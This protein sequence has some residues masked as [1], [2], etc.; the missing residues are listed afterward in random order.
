MWK[1]LRQLAISVGG[2]RQS[3]F[4]GE[5]V[6]YNALDNAKAQIIRTRGAHIAGNEGDD[7]AT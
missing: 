6:F 3:L 4:D 5:I 2:S 7:D 1:Q